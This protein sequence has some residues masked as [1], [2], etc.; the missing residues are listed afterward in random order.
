MKL[1]ADVVIIGGG[2]IGASVA[3]HLAERGAR[4]VLVLEREPEQGRGSTGRATGGVRAQFSTGINIRMSLYSVRFFANFREATGRDCGYLPVGYLFLAADEAQLGAL[5][6]AR[7]R[8]RAEGLTNVEILDAGEI[9][10]RL[11][12]VRADDLA[13]ASFCPTDGFIDPLAVMRGFTARAE[14]RGARVWR[15]VEVTGVDVEGGRVA[16]VRTT[17]GDVATRVAVNAAGAW[18]AR[19]AR[20]AGVEIPVAPLR[21]RIVC[22]RPARPLP[23]GTPMIIDLS[24]GFHFRAVVRGGKW[25]PEVL[26]AWP[27]PSEREGFSTDTDA[28]FAGKILR[29]APA[30]VPSFAGAEVVPE[31]SRAGLY[32]MTPDRH[33][34]IC[35]TRAPRGLFLANGFSGHGVMHS[36]AAGRAVSDLVLDG[37]TAAFDLAPLHLDRFSSGALIEE[38][39]LL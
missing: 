6:S 20:L 29:R 15:G 28:A 34:I 37:H 5:E 31:L 19:V 16:R 22:A 7:S 24:D 38:T 26:L 35:E 1:T 32:E 9:A 3:Y 27:D 17:R 11:P 33:A 39:S 13:G 23:A 18:G 10:R 8:Q 4:D 2:V 36:P 21:C 12:F 30:R 14:E 25:R